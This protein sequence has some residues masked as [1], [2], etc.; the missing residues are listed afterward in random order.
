[1]LPWPSSNGAGGGGDS[2]LAIELLNNVPDLERGLVDIAVSP[3][4]KKAR[5][6]ACQSVIFADGQF[7]G[8][9]ELWIFEAFGRMIKVHR[10]GWVIGKNRSMGPA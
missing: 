10:G 2:R 4:L 3:E 5:L 6:V 7:V 8:V 9:D 1:V